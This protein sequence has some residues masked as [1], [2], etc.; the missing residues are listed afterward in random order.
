MRETCFSQ[1]RQDEASA[2]YPSLEDCPGVPNSRWQRACG[3]RSSSSTWSSLR[4]ISS[5]RRRIRERLLSEV[6]NSP[7]EEAPAFGA[8]GEP[9]RGKLAVRIDGP[10]RPAASRRAECF[11]VASPTSGDLFVCAKH[12]LAEA[13]AAMIDGRARAGD[14][15]LAHI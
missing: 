14:L 4:S 3:V 7:K 13:I 11:L 1:R 5:R 2:S 15:T 10:S 8:G 6:M 12:L 9:S